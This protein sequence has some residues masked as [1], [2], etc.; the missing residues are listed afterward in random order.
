MNEFPDIRIAFG[1][2]DEFSF[3]FHK[4]TTLY[5]RRA[6]KLI[7]LV[8]SAF[9]GNYIRKWPT[10][11]QDVPLQCTPL[12]DGRAICY[13]SDQNL[14]DYLSWRQCDTH[15]NCLYNACYWALVKFGKSAKEAQETLKVIR[16][17][18]LAVASIEDAPSFLSLSFKYSLTR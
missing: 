2:S 13:P 4:W 8:S 16:G 5:G 18:F 1:E 9:T 14:R 7:S 6:S 17:K 15:I 12:F 10:Y 3:V 11:F